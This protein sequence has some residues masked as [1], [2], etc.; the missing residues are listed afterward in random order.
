MVKNPKFYHRVL[1]EGSLG[2][3]ES[4]MDG[5]WDSEKLDG[6]M[7]KLLQYK[8]DNKINKKKI[9]ALMPFS[10]NK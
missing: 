8:M 10:I 7:C 9:K 3:G 5:W 1:A 4:Y 6:T 2:F